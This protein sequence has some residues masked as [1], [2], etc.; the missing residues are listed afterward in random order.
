MPYATYCS[1]TDHA[2]HKFEFDAVRWDRVID[3]EFKINP[4]K[5][6]PGTDP[7]APLAADFGKHKRHIMLLA[8]IKTQKQFNLLR[9]YCL[10]DWFKNPPVTLVIGAA[11][12]D[13]ISVNGVVA[14]MQA[15][16]NVQDNFLSIGIQ[17]WVT[18]TFY[19]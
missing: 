17:F 8:K 1:I 19:I 7:N 12:A 11:G 14:Q 5:S 13:Q 9:Q 6:F 16:W 4:T 2:N 15:S 3:R 18:S 10:K